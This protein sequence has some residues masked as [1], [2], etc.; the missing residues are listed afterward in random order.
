MKNLKDY[1]GHK[2]VNLSAKLN[3]IPAIGWINETINDSDITFKGSEFNLL[4]DAALN[5]LG[6]VPLSKD[7]AQQ[8]QGLIAVMPEPKEWLD[9]LWLVTHRDIH[10]SP[11]VQ[12]FTQLLKSSVR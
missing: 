8:K 5:G 10:H 4:A 11:K 6:L 12:A 1:K 2:F 9:N 7:I 3:H